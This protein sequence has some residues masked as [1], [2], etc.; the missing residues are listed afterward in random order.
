MADPAR[1]LSE[2]EKLCAER[3]LAAVRVVSATEMAVIFWE[4]STFAQSYAS[5]KRAVDD[6]HA[7]QRRMQEFHD[8]HNATRNQVRNRQGEQS[9]GNRSAA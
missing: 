3:D 5:L 9:N 4:A 8:L 6:Y 7:V 1:A 2:F